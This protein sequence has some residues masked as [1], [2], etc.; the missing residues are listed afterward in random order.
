MGIIDKLKKE[1]KEQSVFEY[2]IEKKKEQEKPEETPQTKS[3]DIVVRELGQQPPE[4]QIVE[5]EIPSNEDQ[6]DKRVSEF[7][8]EGMHEFDIE[9]LGASSDAS[10]KIEYKAMIAKMIDESKIDDA[11]ELLKELRERLAKQK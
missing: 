7:R 6:E 9:S 10:I 11:I 1:K 2:L 3:P 5:P 8:T 4:Q